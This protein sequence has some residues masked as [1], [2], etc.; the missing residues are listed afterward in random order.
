MVDEDENTIY[1]PKDSDI[2]I[3]KWRVREGFPVRISQV[4]LLY[5][6]CNEDKEIKRLK[7][8]KTGVVKKRLYEDGDVVEKGF[9]VYYFYYEF[10]IFSIVFNIN[11]LTIIF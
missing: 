9:V 3:I 10:L 11:F 5:E 7:A 8:H 1:A 4:I 6:Y 2:K